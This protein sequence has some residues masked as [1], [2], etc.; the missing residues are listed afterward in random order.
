MRI[1]YGYSKDKRPDLKQFVFATLCVDRAVPIWGTPEDGNVSDKTVN[2]T[3]LSNIATFLGK[4]GVAPGAYIYVADAALGTAENLAALGDTLFITRLPAT[5]NECGRLIAAAVAH[6]AWEDVGVLAPI[7]SRP[8]IVLRLL[9]KPR[10]A[11]SRSM[12]RS[13]EPW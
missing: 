7:R 9:I 11:R 1:T 3:L 6:N 8:S 10:R 12:G 2:N 13:I 5:Y 4:H